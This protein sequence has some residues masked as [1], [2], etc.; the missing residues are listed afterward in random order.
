M[1]RPLIGAVGLALGV[2]PAA[3]ADDWDDYRERI[4]DRREEQRE[5]YEDW[6]ED[7]RDAR[8]D[9]RDRLR[10]EQRR[11]NRGGFGGQPAYYGGTSFYP[12]A[13]Y[14]RGPIYTPG[15]AYY[16]GWADRR[17]DTYRPGGFSLRGPRGRGFSF[18]W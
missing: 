17:Y 14:T 2:A 16:P 4:E 12:G 5:R 6:L 7:Q 18:R 13:G 15:P 1:I 9:Y 10:D 8:E 3:R 11:W